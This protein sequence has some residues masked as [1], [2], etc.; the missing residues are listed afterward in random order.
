MVRLRTSWEP[1]KLPASANSKVLRKSLHE[2]N[3]LPKVSKYCVHVVS[4]D[5]FSIAAGLA[6]SAAGFAALVR[7]IVDLYELPE[8]STELSKAAGQWSGS[9]WRSLFGGYVR[10]E[11]DRRWIGAMD[12]WWKWHRH[13]TGRIWKP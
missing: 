3:P 12:K 11:W 6:S 1:G 13:L 4:E 2:V 8:P 7:A 10:W 9:A 5:N